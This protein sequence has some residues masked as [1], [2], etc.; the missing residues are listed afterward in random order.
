MH[1]RI[2]QACFWGEGKDR[3]RYE[4]G[5]VIEAPEAVV[6]QN[7]WMKPTD[8]PLKEAKAPKEGN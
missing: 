2:E 7:P 4:A 1:V 8:E 5:S 6:D 3:K